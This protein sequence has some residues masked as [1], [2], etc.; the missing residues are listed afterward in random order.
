M[1]PVG[2]RRR[3]PIVVAGPLGV[4]IRTRLHLTTSEAETLREIGDFIGRLYRRE[5]ALRLAQ[6]P[7]DRQQQAQFRAERKRALT[8]DTSSRWAGAITRTVEDQYQLGLRAL[9]AHVRSMDSAIG[10]L[11]A[12]CALA[13]GDRDGRITG[14]RDTAERFAKSRRLA[15]LR[16]RASR[17]R[18]L[19]AEG[20]PMVVVG[21]KPLWRTRNR[22]AE[23]GMSEVRWREQWDAAR[24]FLTADGETGKTG[25]NETIRVVPVTGYLRVKVP[26]ALVD[27][28]G[29]HVEIAAPVTFHH[30]RQEWRDR[31]EQ[32]CAVRYDIAFDPCRRRWYLDASWSLEPV[33]PLL[34]TIRSGRVMGVDLNDGH[35]A[36]CVVDASG[37]PVGEPT[38]ITML[39]QGFPAPRRDGRLRAAITALLDGA[40]FAGCGAIV[41]EDLDFDDARSRGRE[42]LGQGRR[43]KRFRRTVAG[44]PTARFRERLRGMASRRDIA[45]VAVDPAYTSKA[46]N[47]YWRARLQQQTQTSGPVVSTHHGAAVAIGRRGLGMKLSCHSSGP[48]HAQRSVTGQPSSLATASHRSVRRVASA[49]SPP[50]PA[51]GW[52]GP[53]ASSTRP[54]PKT[55]RAATGR[56]SLSLTE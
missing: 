50:A 30:R 35:L 17:A 45:V 55:V 36:T 25:G 19:L 3:S 20:R 39:G 14:Y 27:R 52:N 56:Y 6:G 44:I 26:A 41:I 42:T 18:R 47:R 16:G 29:T 37:N 22:L 38:I 23:A 33:Q 10:T 51:G 2:K 15:A 40:E 1:R 32:N 5:L 34:T 43:G 21:G 46:G 53:E 13:P 8:V 49:P 48:R 24:M 4:R 11:Q 31:I 7:I 9:N 12:R 54:R 28:F